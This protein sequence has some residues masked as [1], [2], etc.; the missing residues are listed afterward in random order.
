MATFWVVRGSKET[1]WIERG[2]I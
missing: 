1:F 2:D